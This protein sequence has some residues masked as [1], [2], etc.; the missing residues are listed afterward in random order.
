MRLLAA[1]EL[2]AKL[3]AAARER[4]RAEF[5]LQRMASGHL[6]LFEQVIASKRG[7]SS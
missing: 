2:A 4:V 5:S 1:P 7:D 3:G 6:E